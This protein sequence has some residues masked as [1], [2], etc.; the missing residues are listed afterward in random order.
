MWAAIVDPHYYIALVGQI[1]HHYP[2]TEWKLAVGSGET[3]LIE[4][5]ATGGA[6]TVMACAVVGSDPLAVVAARV[7]E[8]VLAGAARQ[9]GNCTDTAHTQRL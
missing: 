6:S 8:V 2:G 4:A 3:V 7:D 5:F 9:H 1:G